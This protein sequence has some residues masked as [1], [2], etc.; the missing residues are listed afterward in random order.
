VILI[1]PWDPPVAAGEIER[2]AERGARAIS[3]PSNPASFG[4]PSIHDRDR[5][6][7]P[8]FD[9]AQNAGMPL[10]LHLAGGKHMVAT[11]DDAPLM[12]SLAIDWVE[13]SVT[14]VDYLFS[15][16]FERFPGLHICLGEG[17]VGRIP[18]ALE[19]VEQIYAKD[20]HWTAAAD[21]KW[22]KVGTKSEARDTA[23]L[24]QTPP[25]EVFRNHVFGCFIQDVCGAACAR[26]IGIDNL[27][28]ETDYPHSDS[29]WPSS[30]AV[31]KGFLSRYSDVEKCTI[32]EGN[33]RRVFNFEPLSTPASR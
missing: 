2:M 13:A 5:Y 27:M 31:M 32:L 16:V 20:R 10:C 15:T 14:F 4:F 28:V 22:S 18:A 29:T 17:R 21:F 19:R 26:D 30:L 11:S 7:D 25:R 6:W 23:V 33:A 3:F 1:P 9:S 24:L 12:V 8:V